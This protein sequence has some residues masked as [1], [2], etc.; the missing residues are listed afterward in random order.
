MRKLVILI[1]T[2]IIIFGIYFIFKDNSELISNKKQ[3]AEVSLFFIRAGSEELVAVP[4]KIQDKENIERQTLQELINGPTVNEKDKFFSI[5]NTDTK[6]Q[7]FKVENKTAFVDFSEE[8]KRNMAGS[9]QVLAVR[10]QIERTLKQFESVDE[11]IIS[12]NGRTEDILQP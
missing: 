2:V 3:L 11:V 9:M 1:L 5:I 4:R 7:R 8:L 12:I 10:D 6:I